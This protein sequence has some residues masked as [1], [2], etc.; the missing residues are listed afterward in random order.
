MRDHVLSALPHPLRVVIGYILYRK[1]TQALQGQ[2]TGRHTAEETRALG[3]EIWEN[4]NELLVS[5][6]TAA[7]EDAKLFWVL[8]GESPTEAD[9]ALFGFIVSTLVST[10]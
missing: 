8:G 7:V 10:A 6:K 1:T 5:S 2:G 4:I 9:P 3:L